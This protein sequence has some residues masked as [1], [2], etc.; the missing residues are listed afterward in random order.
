[1]V[2]QKPRIPRVPIT[3]RVTYDYEDAYIFGYAENLSKGGIFIK[4]I[5]P[6]GIGGRLMVQFSL[7][8]SEHIIKCEG[9]VIWVYPPESKDKEGHPPG[10]GVEFTKINTADIEQISQFVHTNRDT[11]FGTSSLSISDFNNKKSA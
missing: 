5:T 4:T 1:M 9:R 3:I 7:P 2:N 6:V 11:H 10:M 8:G